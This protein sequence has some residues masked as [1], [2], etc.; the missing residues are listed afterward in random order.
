MRIDSNTPAPIQSDIATDVTSTGTTER[1]A[2][3]TAEANR[4]VPSSKFTPTN[5]LAKLLA[6]LKDT[7]DVRTDVVADV[8]SRI[9]AGELT[10]PTAAQETASAFYDSP[11]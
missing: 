3:K 11:K 6:A 2:G 4:L 7:P 5:D 8:S 1:V 10:T 9:A